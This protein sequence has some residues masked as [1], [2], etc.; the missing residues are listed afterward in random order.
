MHPTSMAIKAII[1]ATPGYTEETLLKDL[2]RNPETVS[3][4]RMLS[5][6]DIRKI[7][8]VSKS[9]VF[10]W[11]REGKLTPIYLNGCKRMLRFRE[12]EVAALR[13]RI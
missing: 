4:E 13:G 11:K 8:S 3:P 9:Q 1:D 12:S 7:L 6:P 10:A 5:T 2:G